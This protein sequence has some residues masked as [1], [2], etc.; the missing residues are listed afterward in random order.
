MSADKLRSV[1][2]ARFAWNDVWEATL[3]ERP[4]FVEAAVRL[5]SVGVST[6]Q[7]DP[8]VRAFLRLALNAALTHLAPQPTRSAIRQAIDAGATREELVEV[9]MVVATLGVHGMNADVL[10]EVLQERGLRT[11]D[12]KL[13]DQQRHIRDEYQRTR[14]YWRD[15]LNHTLELAPDFLSAYLQFSGAPWTVGVLEPKVR[16]FI[17]LAFDTSPTHLHLTGLKIHIDNALGYGAS[18]EEIVEVMGIAATMGLQT[19]DFA[20]PMVDEELK[21]RPD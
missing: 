3:A 15:F 7:L 9:L 17:Y 4:E 20:M 2:S 21:G 5:D 10:A 19:L 12:S 13:T 6:G 11:S 18:A 8:K 1:A 14:G 16:E